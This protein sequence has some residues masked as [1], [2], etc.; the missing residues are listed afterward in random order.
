MFQQTTPCC[1]VSWWCSAVNSAQTVCWVTWEKEHHPAT[2][3][4]LSTKSNVLASLTV[5]RQ[6]V[7]LPPSL[8][9]N[10]LFIPALSTPPYRWAMPSRLLLWFGIEVTQWMHA[11]PCLGA[12]RKS[13]KTKS[14]QRT[15]YNQGRGDTILQC[16]EMP[17][18]PSS[19]LL[20]LPAS[21]PFPVNSSALQDH[22]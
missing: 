4:V 16:A 20:P 18:S 7:M 12:K 17:S 22:S 13:Q 2:A 14:Y 8:R 21:S 9:E 11:C 15:M 6:S 5:S 1:D 10:R 3:A 19:C